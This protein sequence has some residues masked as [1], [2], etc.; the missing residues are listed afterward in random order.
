MS[1]TANSAT[2]RTLW[3]EAL[4]TTSK[5]NYCGKPGLKQLAGKHIAE[6]IGQ[7]NK[8]DTAPESP[9]QA[10]LAMAKDSHMYSTHSKEG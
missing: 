9:R 1:L 10:N 7:L 3:K 5:K 8:F 4:A 6:M 2:C